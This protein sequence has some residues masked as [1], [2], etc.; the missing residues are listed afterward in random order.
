MDEGK[1][2]DQLRHCQRRRLL[3][4]GVDQDEGSVDKSDGG[5]SDGLNFE[6]SSIGVFSRKDGGV[7]WAGDDGEAEVWK[8]S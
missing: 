4:V 1:G 2:G 7:L 8:S 5:E 6:L 3:W